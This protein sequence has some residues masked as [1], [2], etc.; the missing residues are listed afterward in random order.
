MAVNPLLY[1]TLF[2]NILYSLLSGFS[3]GL[4]IGGILQAYKSYSNLK[5]LA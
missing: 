4:F 1:S 5:A 3:V 2:F